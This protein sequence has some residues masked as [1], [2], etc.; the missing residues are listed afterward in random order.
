[1]WYWILAMLVGSWVFADAR[2]RKMGEPILWAL[3]T[4]ILMMIVLPF[5]FAKRSLRAGEVREG[6]V[7]WNVIKSFAI[8]WTVLMFVSGLIGLGATGALVSSASSGAERAGAAIGTMLGLGMIVGSWLIVL[9]GAV[10]VGL[11]VKK[12]SIIERGPTGALA[13]PPDG[14]IV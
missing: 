12:A 1:M 4:V 7:A 3:G 5:Y 9:V 10:G 14:S 11:L 2:S 13:L 6:G 8:M